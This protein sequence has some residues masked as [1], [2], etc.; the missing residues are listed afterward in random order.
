M[1]HSSLQNPLAFNDAGVSSTIGHYDGESNL[2]M[3]ENEKLFV[4]QQESC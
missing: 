2:S 4:S 1:I 3:N